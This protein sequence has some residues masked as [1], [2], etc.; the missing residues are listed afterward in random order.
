MG[1]DDLE[2]GLVEGVH[3]DHSCDGLKDQK[4]DLV[5]IKNRGDT[6]MVTNENPR[7]SGNAGPPPSLYI[8]RSQIWRCPRWRLSGTGGGYSCDSLEDTGRGPVIVTWDRIT[9]RSEDRPQ[10]RESMSRGGVR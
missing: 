5:N 10:K 2:R 1:Q 7:A 9:R 4:R 3:K 8:E 6:I